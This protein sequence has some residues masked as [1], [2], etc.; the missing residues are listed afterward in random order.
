[1]KLRGYLRNT[2]S[3]DSR[4][5]KVVQLESDGKDCLFCGYASKCIGH[6]LP[7]DEKEWEI[8]ARYN[9]EANFSFGCIWSKE[10]KELLNKM[11]EQR[12]ESASENSASQKDAL[13]LS[14]CL[15]AFC[16]PETLSV[17]DPW[18]C[19]VCKGHKQATKKMDLWKLPEIF[20][21]HLKRFS[22]TRTWREKIDSFVDFPVTSLSVDGHSQ[23]YD[24]YAISNHIGS[25]GG[26]HYTAYVKNL[27]NGEW[28]C[29]DDQNVTSVAVSSLK[30]S[31]AYVLFYLRRPAKGKSDS[32]VVED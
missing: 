18:Y 13:A 31:M 27:A 23:Q 17:D 20:I 11:E 7:V 22:Y 32:Q 16:L 1:L 25:M 3:T 30:S 10:G 9:K 26:G 6:E 4:P 8:K 21:I 5:Y 2:D 19:S 15:K 24:L 12:H 14:D 28:Y 29:H